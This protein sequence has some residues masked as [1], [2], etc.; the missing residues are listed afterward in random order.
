MRVAGSRLKTVSSSSIRVEIRPVLTGVK[1][2]ECSR[3]EKKGRRAPADLRLK[4]EKMSGNTGKK[5]R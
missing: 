4:A 2:E 3:S 5:P 1:K